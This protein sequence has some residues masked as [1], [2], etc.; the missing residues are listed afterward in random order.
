MLRIKHIDH[1]VIRA[2]DL[3]EMIGFYCDVVGCTID[4]RVDELGLVHLRAGKS[5]IDLISVEGKLG[6]TGGAP[7]EVEKRNMDHLC[8]RLE[9]FRVEAILAHLAAHGIEASDV[10]NNYGAEGYGASIYIKDP[11]GN[12]IEF[13][14]PA[15]SDE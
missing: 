1:L 4:K 10:Y 9:D 3:E 11:E 6:L 15:S 13:K 8:L 12:T 5:M 14:G 7:P 2:K